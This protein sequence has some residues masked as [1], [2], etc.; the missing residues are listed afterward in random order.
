MLKNDFLGFPKVKWLHLTSEVDKSVKCSCHI[1]QDL[2]YQ[3]L[4][5]ND[6]NDRV[7]QKIKRWTFFGTQG[8]NN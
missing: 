6:F 7:I 4:E 8:A 3:N 2:T 5:I 1:S